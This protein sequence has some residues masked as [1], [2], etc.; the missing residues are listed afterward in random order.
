M[1]CLARMVHFWPYRWS[2]W[3]LRIAFEENVPDEVSVDCFYCSGTYLV[4]QGYHEIFKKRSKTNRSY[5]MGHRL[6]DKP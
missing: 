3:S 4:L 5:A 6:C 1:L 2:P